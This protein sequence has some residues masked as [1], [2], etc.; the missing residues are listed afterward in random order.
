MR[1]P[2]T[3][4]VFSFALLFLLLFASAASAQ[5]QYYGVDAN[6]DDK[7]KVS[8]QMTLTFSQ[9]VKD[10]NFTIEGSVQK[11]SVNSTAG[12]QNCLLQVSGI[13]VVNC[14]LNLTQDKRTVIF[15]FD[16]FDFVRDVDGKFFLDSDF[17]LDKNIEQVAVTVKLPEGNAIV[18]EDVPNRISFPEVANI[19]SDG[20]RIIVNWRFTQ[21]SA[22]QPLKFQ[23]LYE[24][25]ILP[26]LFDFRIR[27]AI[28]AGG[29]IGLVSTFAYLRYFRKA[30]KVIL[31]VLDEYERKVFDLIVAA[32]GTVNQ[33]KIVQE[34]NLSKA[35]ISRVVKSLVD[36]GVIEVEHVGRTNK[37]KVLKKKFLM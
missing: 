30:E 23:I 28:I 20:R 10:F 19:I 35:K 18:S 8:V 13:T 17:S 12:P 24:T 32:G 33:K 34:T 9:I 26:P 1:H 22:A 25:I 2:A 27:Y 11:F 36:R 3:V 14:K 6:I 31:S 21:T 5:V 37:L 7:G 4:S 29:I 16:T 15:N